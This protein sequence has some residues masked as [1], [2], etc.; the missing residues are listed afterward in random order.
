MT[1]WESKAH[2]YAGDVAIL[3]D[4]LDQA[5]AEQRK[6]EA[7]R[8]SLKRRDETLR[9][10]ARL[11]RETLAAVA[12]SIG[13]KPGDCL[14]ERV[15]DLVAERDALAEEVKLLREVESAGVRVRDFSDG[16][17]CDEVAEWQGFLLAL[18]ALRQW[19]ER[20]DA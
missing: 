7:E 12:L 19:R 4:L 16:E 18:A 14:E 17:L 11:A 10:N 2:E 6:L 13:A 1:D 8:D 3:R 15:A 9:T 5:Q 20:R